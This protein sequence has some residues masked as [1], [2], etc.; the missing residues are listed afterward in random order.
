M[1]ELTYGKGATTTTPRNPCEPLSHTLATG[2]RR[3]LKLIKLLN[4]RKFADFIGGTHANLVCVCAP[5]TT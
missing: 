2:D 3:S 4:A 1:R 5:Y